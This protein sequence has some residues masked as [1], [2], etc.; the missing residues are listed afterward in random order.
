MYSFADRVAL[1][2]G[3]AGGIGRELA[4]LLAAEGA[5]IAA[6]DRSADGLA[7]LEGELKSAGG[8]CQSPSPTSR[9]LRSCAT[10]WAGWSRS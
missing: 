6:L 8:R 10:P 4:R 7:V 3:A 1:I 9:I 5:R 2:T